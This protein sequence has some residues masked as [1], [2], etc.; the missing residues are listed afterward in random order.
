VSPF[1]ILTD[2]DEVM[3]V[4]GAGLDVITG[5]DTVLH[6]GYDGQFGETTQIHVITLKGSAKF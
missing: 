1:T 4:V 5:T 3:G 2:I 6:A